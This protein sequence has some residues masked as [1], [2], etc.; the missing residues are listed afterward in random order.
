M[1]ARKAVISRLVLKAETLTR[2]VPVC[3]VPPVAWAKGEQCSPARTA[4]PRRLSASPT[5]PGSFCGK[6]TDRPPVW[7]PA[8]GAA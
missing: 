2:T 1:A 6:R 7:T 8:P 4:M 5:Q 3:S